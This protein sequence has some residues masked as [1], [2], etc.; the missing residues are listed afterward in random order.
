MTRRY[1]CSALLLAASAGCGRENQCKSELIDDSGKFEA[2]AKGRKP[3]A[4]LR[5]EALRA[6]CGRRCARAEGS[7]EACVSRCVVDADAGK[8]GV[9]ITCGGR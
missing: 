3:E 5:R 9:R 8:I 4:E 6:A 1:L 2:V 7:A